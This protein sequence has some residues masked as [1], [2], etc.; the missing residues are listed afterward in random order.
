MN[1]SIPDNKQGKYQRSG[2]LWSS[3]ELNK[4]A[5]KCVRENA[6]VKG[7]PNLTTAS[8]CRWINDE[9]LPNVSLP[10]GFPRRVSVETARKWLH[11]QH[12][13]R[14]K[15]KQHQHRKTTTT[16]T[17][18]NNN[19]NTE[20]NNKKTPTP[21]PPVYISTLTDVNMHPATSTVHCYAG[22]SAFELK[23]QSRGSSQAIGSAILASFVE[24]TLHPGLNP[25]YP[26]ILLNC[27][28]LKVIFYDCANDH[29]FISE[30]VHSL[31]MGVEIKYVSEQYL[32]CGLSS[33][34]GT[35]WS[36]RHLTYIPTFIAN[37]N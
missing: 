13:H 28:S 1:G 3:E 2:I 19:T 30:T 21:T 17:P 10:P 5:C 35:Y 6:N 11:D 23:R 37:L 14:K 32:F 4:K 7:K 12:Q 34:T 24:R 15:Q 8:F 16:P 26:C 20:K 25:L 29:L 31:W 36:T 9:L 18:K 33:I 22:T 27:T